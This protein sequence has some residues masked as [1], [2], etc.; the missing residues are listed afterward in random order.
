MLTGAG[1]CTLLLWLV[2][3]GNASLKQALPHAMQQRLSADMKGHAAM[4]A[5][6]HKDGP[7]C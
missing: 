7:V 1:S 3:L 2:V 6:E 5:E 4:L